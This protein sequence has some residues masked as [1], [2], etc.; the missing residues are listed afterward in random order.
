MMAGTAMQIVRDTNDALTRVRIN[1]VMG[2]IAIGMC[3]VV[4]LCWLMLKAKEGQK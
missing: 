2:Y 4:C 3:A 1:N